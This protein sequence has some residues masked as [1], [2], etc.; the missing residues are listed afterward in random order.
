M[1]FRD[2]AFICVCVN[3]FYIV[4]NSCR[5]TQSSSLVGELFVFSSISSKLVLG[6][7]Q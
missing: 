3:L 5:S 1:F 6:K 2:L 4:M 7:T